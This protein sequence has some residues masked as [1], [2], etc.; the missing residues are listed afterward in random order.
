MDKLFG[1]IIANTNDLPPEEKKRYQQVYCGLCREL[2][3]RHGQL[4]RLS[5]NYDMTFLILLLSSLYE[6]EEEHGEIR[7]VVH[8]VGKHAY[9]C[10][11][12]TRYAA[13]MTVALSYYKCMDDW[14]DD[15]KRFSRLYA[16]ALNHAYSEVKEQWPRQCCAIETCMQELSQIEQGTAGPDEAANCFGRLM[17]ELFIYAEDVWSKPLRQFGTCLGRFIYIMD[18][19]VGYEGDQAKNRYNPILASGK[20][21]ADMQEAMA[22]QI[23]TAAEIFE[24][25]PLVADVHLLRSVIY[26]GVWQKY[27]MKNAR[28]G[29]NDGTGSI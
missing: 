17:A 18:A 6:P 13:D 22:I 12:Y 2:G 20:K 10:N 16:G 8:P 5:L 29:N 28:K 15:R 21:P 27:Q 9:I 25:L 26:A 19:A 7:C 14:I 24:K 1:Y 11:R 23:G 3:R 4:S